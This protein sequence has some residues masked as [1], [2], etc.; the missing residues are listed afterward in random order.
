MFEKFVRK[1][2]SYLI[3]SILA[4]SVLSL[5][6][7]KNTSI[8]LTVTQ[9]Y[10][11]LQVFILYLSFRVLVAKLSAISYWNPQNKYRSSFSVQRRKLPNCKSKTTFRGLSWI[12][13]FGAIKPV[14]C[15]FI[16]TFLYDSRIF[17]EEG[18]IFDLWSNSYATWFQV[19]FWTEISIKF[20]LVQ[21]FQVRTDFR[22]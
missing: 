11:W 3:S 2:T 10:T 18:P 7:T 22:K 21:T 19:Q 6:K 17:T 13:R 12:R 1:I 15:A 4:S 14:L 20:L 5:Y 9:N 16:M 8:K